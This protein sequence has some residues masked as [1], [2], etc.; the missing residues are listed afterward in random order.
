MTERETIRRAKEYMDLLARGVDPI[1]GE[2]LPEESPLN[3]VRMTRCFL[4]VSDILQQMLANGWNTG[5]QEAFQITPA[6]L[7]QVPI[8]REPLGITQF[9]ENINAVACGPN[10]KKLKTTT[11]TDWLLKKGFLEKRQLSD[12]KCPRLPTLRGLELGISSQTRM[13]Q[14]GEYV[15]VSYD[16]NAQRFLLDNLEAI[17]RAQ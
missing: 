10:M 2:E 12:G 1:T 6:Q 17:L 15:A 4:Y 7:K 13:G 8:S 16:A 14:R 3:H 5:K 11:I 9:A